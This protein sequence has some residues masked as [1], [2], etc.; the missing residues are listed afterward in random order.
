MMEAILTWMAI[1]FQEDLIWIYR[2]DKVICLLNK[3]FSD[4]EQK[5]KYFSSL[6]DSYNF[7][8]LLQISDNQN[9]YLNTK[10]TLICHQLFLQILGFILEIF[11]EEFSAFEISSHYFL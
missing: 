4:V 5:A 6:L 8:W 1:L 9:I 7:I 3:N 11:K 2:N 10:Q